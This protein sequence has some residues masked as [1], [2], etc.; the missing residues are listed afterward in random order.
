[1]SRRVVSPVRS[2]TSPTAIGLA[3]PPLP[4]LMV[5]SSV[6]GR[7]FT[8]MLPWGVMCREAPVS[9]TH[10]WVLPGVLLL[11]LNPTASVPC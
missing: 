1:M 2:I 5:M 4:K 10:R 7:T 3:L 9:S 11:L 6:M 8:M